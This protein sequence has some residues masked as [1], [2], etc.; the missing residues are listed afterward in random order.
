MSAAERTQTVL[1]GRGVA[2]Y[3]NSHGG[4]L[5]VWG[6]PVGGFEWMKASTERPEGVE[7]AL[8][9]SVREFELCM[10]KDLI[11]AR[12]LRLARR[13]W[14]PGGGVVVDTGLVVGA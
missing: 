14:L 8:V 3:V 2:S 5:Y 6:D 13:W 10:E 9:A 4:C 11:G 12:R 1:I 7:L